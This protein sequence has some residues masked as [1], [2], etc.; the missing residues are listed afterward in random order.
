MSKDNEE[1]DYQEKEIRQMIKVSTAIYCAMISGSEEGVSDDYMDA[2]VKRA[3]RSAY[4]LIDEVYE[5][6]VFSHSSRSPE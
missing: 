3:V 2:C 6:D 1:E 5:Q 4:T